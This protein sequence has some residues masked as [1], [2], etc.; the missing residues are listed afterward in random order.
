MNKRTFDKHLD[1]CSTKGKKRIDIEKIK[2]LPDNIKK[3]MALFIIRNRCPVLVE[4]VT[5]AIDQSW[6]ASMGYM[7]R[8]RGKQYTFIHTC[9][10]EIR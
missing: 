4:L 2:A 5:D 1:S 7:Y 9:E 6:L 8:T 3:E 10:H